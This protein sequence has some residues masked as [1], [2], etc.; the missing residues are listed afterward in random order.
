MRWMFIAIRMEIHTRYISN[1]GGRGEIS[2][3]VTDLEEIN[4]K[5]KF[6]HYTS[7]NNAKLILSGGSFYLSRLDRLNDLGETNLHE[8]EKDRIYV[9]SFCHSTPKDIPMFYLYSGIDGK[10]CCIRFTPNKM[11]KMISECDVYSISEVENG[12]SFDNSEYEIHFGWVYYKNDGAFTGKYRGKSFNNARAGKKKITDSDNQYFIKDRWWE[13]EKEFRIVVLFKSKIEMEKVALKFPVEKYKQGVSIVCGPELDET[14]YL[15][16]KK[17][18]SDIGF[19]GIYRIKPKQIRMGLIE[20]SE[21]LLK[22]NQN[23]GEK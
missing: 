21:E 8:D 10:G 12:K 5:T 11:Q 16:A 19:N 9:A 4:G 14:E 15:Q 18:F 3:R 6:C 7:M 13:Y 1:S 20:K 2:M 23:K 22:R 17:D